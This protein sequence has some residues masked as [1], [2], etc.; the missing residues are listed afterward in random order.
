[1]RILTSTLLALSFALPCYG[2]YDEYDDGY[3]EARNYRKYRRDDED[4]ELA[5][6]QYRQDTQRA[7][8]DALREDRLNRGLNPI[9]GEDPRAG[10][11]DSIVPNRYWYMPRRP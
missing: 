8:E 6:Q 1:M 10:R 3:E 7:V 9:T 4:R 2:Q 5:R 11:P